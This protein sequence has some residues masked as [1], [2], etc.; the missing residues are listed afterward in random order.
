[1]WLWV[2]SFGLAP[3]SARHFLT[4]SWESLGQVIQALWAS[5][6]S[7]TKWGDNIC[8]KRVV[9]RNNWNDV[10]HSCT[11]TRICLINVSSRSLLPPFS[12]LSL[13][14]PCLPTPSY[15]FPALPTPRKIAAGLVWETNTS[16]RPLLFA[17]RS[18]VH[19]SRAASNSFC[20]TCLLG[21]WPLALEGSGCFCNSYLRAYHYCVI[22]WHLQV[23]LSPPEEAL[24]SRTASLA[25]QHSR[26]PD[27][28]V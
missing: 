4:T 22:F 15:L 18:I 20:L 23:T 6:F 24:G 17:C 13:S 16:A 25:I 3:S 27:Q 28:T 7:S 19:S 9:L 1:M 12:F 2:K 14:P 21:P 8:F 11:W 10:I 5:D 26:S